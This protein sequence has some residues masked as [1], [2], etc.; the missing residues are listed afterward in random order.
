MVTEKPLDC[1]SLAKEDGRV[2]FVKDAIPGDVVDVKITKTNGTSLPFEEN[3]FE[4]VFTATVLQHNTDETMLKTLISEIC[5]VSSDR[6]FLFE[7]IEKDI[8]GDELCYGRPISYYENILKA[9]GFDL[10]STKFIN[11]RSSYYV[12]GAIRKLFNKKDRKEGEPLSHFSIFLQNITLPVTS[13]FDKIFPSRKDV[14]R[15]EFAKK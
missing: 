7:R 14:C 8:K 10:R 12:S 5:R 4:I 6:V 13:V 11:I 9:H 3:A 1:K 15:M 2:I